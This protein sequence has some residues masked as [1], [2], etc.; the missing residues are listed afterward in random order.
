[1][2]CTKRT[3]RISHGK[4]SS[5]LACRSR[6]ALSSWLLHQS[7]RQ[8]C[9]SAALTSQG[10]LTSVPNYAAALLF[11]MVSSRSYAA[12]AAGGILPHYASRKVQQ[13]VVTTCSLA[14]SSCLTG[15]APCWLLVQPVLSTCYI[16]AFF[17]GYDWLCHPNALRAMAKDRKNTTSWPQQ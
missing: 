8:P 2:C 11:M 3:L 15:P 14:S 9:W 1:M 6:P 12:L 17:L 16:T 7:F 5:P 10:R 13:A 4:Y